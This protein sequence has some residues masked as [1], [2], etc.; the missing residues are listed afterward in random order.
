MDSSGLVGACLLIS[1]PPNLCQEQLTKPFN[2]S[3]PCLTGKRTRETGRISI[4]EGRMAR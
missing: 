2:P 4:D 3:G 1:Q